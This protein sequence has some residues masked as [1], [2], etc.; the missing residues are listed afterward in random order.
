VKKP[1]TN[2]ISAEWQ[3]KDWIEGLIGQFRQENT[4]FGGC[5]QP[6]LHK[7]PEI[8]AEVARE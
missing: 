3:N 4:G 5:L 1:K 6:A 7:V 8:R 2:K